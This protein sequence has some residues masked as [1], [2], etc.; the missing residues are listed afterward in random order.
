MF[1]AFCLITAHRAEGEGRH[2]S[3]YSSYEKESDKKLFAQEFLT[4]FLHLGYLTPKRLIFKSDVGDLIS[5]RFQNRVLD[6]DNI[7]EKTN[8]LCDALTKINLD[9]SIPAKVCLAMEKFIIKVLKSNQFRNCSECKICARVKCDKDV[10]ENILFV[11][12]DLLMF[13]RRGIAEITTL[14]INLV[15]NYD[16]YMYFIAYVFLKRLVREHIK[17]RKLPLY[18]SNPLIL[19]SFLSIACEL[20]SEMGSDGFFYLR[21]LNKTNYK[22]SPSEYYCCKNSLCDMMLMNFKIRIEEVNE[23]VE[24]LSQ[25]TC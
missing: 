7:E 13:I 8:N 16:P 22:V 1:I 12:S 23:I 20:T 2:I 10:L 25:D 14:M 17:C 9:K 24:E 4:V 18:L 11:Y 3:Y 6:N 21:E 5:E 15:K 19:L